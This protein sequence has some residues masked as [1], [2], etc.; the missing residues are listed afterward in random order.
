M[1]SS[2]TAGTWH[3]CCQQHFLL[4]PKSMSLVLWG[5]LPRTSNPPQFCLTARGQ[6][7]CWNTPSVCSKT[8]KLPNPRWPVQTPLP[9]DIT[10]GHSSCSPSYFKTFSD[11]SNINSD[12]LRFYCWLVVFGFYKLCH[13]RILLSVIMPQN[14]KCW[15][16]VFPAFHSLHSICAATQ[17]TE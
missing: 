6:A 8:T 9:V 11:V 3:L 10:T 16:S 17:W 15:G 4:V 12:E 5:F 1:R 13:N 14:T 7:G 2:C